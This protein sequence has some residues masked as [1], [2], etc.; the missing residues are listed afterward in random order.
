MDLRPGCI[1]QSCRLREE[2]RVVE[3]A[4]TSKRVKAWAIM[5]KR[6]NLVFDADEQA[7]IYRRR[8]TADE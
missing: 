6:G 5:G 4:M 8:K 7:V 2:D 1:P 3:E